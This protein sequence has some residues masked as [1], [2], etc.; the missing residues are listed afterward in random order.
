MSNVKTRPRPLL[1]VVPCGGLGN[2]L[3]AML[4]ARLLAEQ[5]GC[6]FRVAWRG[7]AWLP[8]SCFA[9][10]DV[11]SDVEAERWEG[12]DPTPAFYVEHHAP[13]SE[14]EV[15]SRLMSGETV[16]LK[17]FCFIKPTG[18]ELAAFDEAI[19]QQFARLRPQ[20]AVLNRV[21]EVPAPS[22]GLQVRRGD[23]WRSILYSPLALFCEA[24][25]QCLRASP[26]LHL[27]LATDS[28]HV[29]QALR[30]R[31]GQRLHH[32]ALRPEG[33]PRESARDALADMLALSRTR[34]IFTSGQS[35]F[36]YIAHLMTRVPNQPLHVAWMSSDWTGPRVIQWHDRYM[37]WNWGE[38]RWQ[39]NSLRDPTMADRARA[40]CMQAVNKVVCSG[41]YQLWP[42]HHGASGPIQ[43]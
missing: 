22:I 19:H 2:R 24:V 6:A 12:P 14:P 31:Y 29:Q 16:V 9:L 37:H 3:M 8:L 11:L 23:C 21:P 18:M 39:R 1:V 26:D 27:F 43:R 13:G 35:S 38:Q 30:R 28:I 36:G 33:D 25:D 20:P 32:Q 10:E 40:C 17:S 15:E 4:S 5:L 42:F 41:L 7:E 34:Q